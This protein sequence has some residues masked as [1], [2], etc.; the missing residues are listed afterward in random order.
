[1]INLGDKVMDVITGFTGVATAR[2]EYINGCV[3]YEVQPDKL[4]DGK[5]IE[6]IWVDSQQLKI[7]QNN[8]FLKPIPAFSP[9]KKEKSGG[10][11]STPNIRMPKF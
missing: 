2:I 9:G 7:V 8:F 1:M 11:G 10:S 3:R 5:P 4:K 6:A